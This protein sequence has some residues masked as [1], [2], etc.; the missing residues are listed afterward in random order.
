MELSQIL[1]KLQPLMPEQVEHWLQTL[2]TA[3]PEVKALLERQI[4]YTAHKVLGDFRN[5]ILLSLPP[6]KKARGIFHLGTVLYDQEKWPV[7]LRA[8][9]LMQNLAIFG[10]SGAGKTNVAFHI[11]QQLS[12]KGIRFL[13]LDWKRTARHLLP[14]FQNKIKVYTPGRMLS[15]F[16][17]NPFLAP[18]GCEQ[19]VYLNHLIDVIGD[20]YTLGDGAKS[21]LQKSI[22]KAYQKNKSPT[23]SDVL[24]EISKMQTKGRAGG[25][26]ISARRALESMELL[27][28]K[29]SG[30]EQEKFAKSLLKQNTVVEL[31][32]LS[33]SSKKF[34]IPLLCFW[35]YMVQ[36]A[37]DKR[38]KLSLVIFVEEAHHV[39]YRQE[40]RAKESLMNILLRQCRELGIGFIVIDQHPHL[41]SSA[42][43]GNCFTTIC[44]NQKDPTDINKAAGLS[45]LDES[46]KRFLSMLPV[47]QGIVKLQD[48]WLR[49]FLVKFPLVNVRKGMIND[50]LLKRFV[51]GRFSEQ[52]AGECDFGFSVDKQHSPFGA[53]VLEEGSVSLLHDIM[54]FPD[55]GVDQRY[56]RLGTSV[57]VGNRWKSQ[58]LV[59]GLVASERVK[60]GN[61]YRVLLKP[62]LIAKKFLL[63][64]KGVDGQ[65]SL[66][67]EYWKQFYAQKFSE[68]GYHVILECPRNA[69]GN[70]GRMD[71][72]AWRV[73]ESVESIAIEIETGKSDTVSNVKR[74]LREEVSKVL[75]VATDD[76]AL[77]KVERQLAEEGLLIPGR[78]E[79]VLRD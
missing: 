57:R 17:F 31:D 70:S 9:E 65:A 24:E 27:D 59:N 43:L 68:K 60:V 23:A 22:A 73:L 69:K 67:H 45:L 15:P 41:I 56:K 35:L 33:Q 14:S 77:K 32:A 51:A 37:G 26:K 74:D 11:L 46:E 3:Q 4:W 61:T 44:L 53:N 2:D 71:V 19:Q 21:I 29:T 8:K 40:H 25:W 38:E 5:K 34:L 42:V 20:A 52:R 13:F 12:D 30:Q 16:P 50:D 64:E 55:H 72:L 58:L 28:S 75:V 18:P 10:R 36:L 48:R 7:G 39:L 6:E 76:R 62:T 54:K 47:G 1:R 79:V 63:S 78:V 49:P 66:L